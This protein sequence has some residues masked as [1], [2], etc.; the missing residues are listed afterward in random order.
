MIEALCNIFR[1]MV[2]GIANIIPGV[3]G[4]TMA[5]AMG[6]YDKLIHAL[7]HIKSE[8][9][10]S[11]K[12]LVPVI[13][14]AGIALVALSFVITTALEKYPIPTNLL[15]IGLIVGGL[16]A[17]CRKVKGNPLKPQHVIA[18]LAFFA[19]VVGM[20]LFGGGKGADA[21]LSFGFVNV[22]IL[23]GCGIIAAATM[24]IPGVSGSMILMLLGYYEPVVAAI[25]DFMTALAHLDMDGV[26]SGLG[27]LVPF[28]LGALFGI[29]VIAKLIEWIF[30][31]YP[32]VAFWAII[33]LI[34][35]SPVAIVLLNTFTYTNLAVTIISS[36]LA[37]GV[38][39]VVSM[40]LGGE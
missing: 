9:K 16:P 35:A 27:I 38:G 24:V 40:K 6:I 37:F 2:I 12:L 5:V 11:M 17:V 39:F 25:K 7:T 15:F 10:K 29:V 22:L 33:G 18:A 13:I 1:G 36:V 19:L 28:G 20:A 34:V 32:L 31:K 8:F 3:S 21:D 4:G 30:R 14:G 23:F 26:V